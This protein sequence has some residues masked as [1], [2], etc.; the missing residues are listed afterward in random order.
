MVVVY[1]KLHLSGVAVLI[2]HLCRGPVCIVDLRPHVITA[3]SALAI[4][5]G[6]CHYKT[7]NRISNTIKTRHHRLILVP[8][9]VRV[10][11]ELGT[12]LV[13]VG[14][15]ALSSN[16]TTA[17]SAV[18]TVITPHNHKTATLNPAHRRLV[19]A[20]RC[21]G[22]HHELS[23]QRRTARI[24]ALGKHINAAASMLAA[25]IIPPCHHKATS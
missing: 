10:H 16:I 11:S 15:K 8:A 12:H 4:W 9:L 23:S 13:S 6:P 18:P 1:T 20:A 2:I 5:I 24:V 17:A 19:L 22:V 25:V 21:V 3:A 14:R 7:A